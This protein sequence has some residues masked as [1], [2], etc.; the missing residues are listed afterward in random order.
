MKKE[1]AIDRVKKLFKL[2]EGNTT[3]HESEQAML[4][5]RKIMAEYQIEMADVDDREDEVVSVCID[6]YVR[7]IH[8]TIGALIAEHFKIK[9]TTGARANRNRILSFVGFQEDVNI[10][11]EVYKFAKESM[12]YHADEY[13]KQNRKGRVDF[14]KGYIQGLVYA[15]EKQEE[16][17]QEAG[18]VVICNPKVDEKHQEITQ[19]RKHKKS[20]TESIKHMRAYFEGVETGENFDMHRKQISE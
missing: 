5:A 8:L 18:L 4:K 15:L 12:E 13:I 6:Q 14:K 16:E 17:L 19:G 3:V 9:S 20:K 1:K 2:S 11:F 10:A 7:G